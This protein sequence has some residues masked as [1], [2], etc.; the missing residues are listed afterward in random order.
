MSS[1]TLNAQTAF[2]SI[3]NIEHGLP[4]TYRAYLKSLR[5]YESNTLGRKLGKV[6]N[7]IL[8]FPI[9]YPLITSSRFF[10]NADGSWPA[11]LMIL[12]ISIFRAMW[13]LHDWVLKPYVGDGETGFEDEKEKER[14]KVD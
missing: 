14:E 3:K 7:M 5:H 10:A 8:F 6:I 4:L 9:L 12:Q 13:T 1:L 2:L 11:C